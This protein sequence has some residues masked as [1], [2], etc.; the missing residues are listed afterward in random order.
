M[1]HA[2]FNPNN[3]Q[4]HPRALKVIHFCVLCTSLVEAVNTHFA[5]LGFAIKCYGN[6]KQT[7]PKKCPPSSTAEAAFFMNVR[8]TSLDAKK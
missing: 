4:T 3:I 5:F 1:A 6:P 8:S 7:L 2:G